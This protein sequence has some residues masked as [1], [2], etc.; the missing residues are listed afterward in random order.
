LRSQLS[1][2][3]AYQPAMVPLFILN[4]FDSCALIGITDGTPM[5]S[6]GV[7]RG[8]LTGVSELQDVDKFVCV[9]LHYES[10]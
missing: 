6:I 8:Q 4:L 3:L 5:T 9:A 2:H 7:S 10:L 1:Q